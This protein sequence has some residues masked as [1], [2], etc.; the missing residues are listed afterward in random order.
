M[1]LATITMTPEHL[2]DVTMGFELRAIE[3]ADQL[4]WA[5]AQGRVED[6]PVLV[7]QLRDLLDEL[8]DVVESPPL[9]A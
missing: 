3:L 8:A 2:A 6:V 5:E 1:R 4:E 9:A 7:A